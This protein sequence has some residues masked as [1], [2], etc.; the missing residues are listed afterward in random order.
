[1]LPFEGSCLPNEFLL[2]VIL[3][4]SLVLFTSCK[5]YCTRDLQNYI[6]GYF[7]PISGYLPHPVWRMPYPSP[8]NYA[9]Q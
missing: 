1:M 8:R 3:F 7:M 5:K 4:F 9:L 2:L 6:M